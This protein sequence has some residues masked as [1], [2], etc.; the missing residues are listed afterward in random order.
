MNK[1]DYALLFEN[2][3]EKHHIPVEVVEQLN[4]YGNVTIAT[5]VLATLTAKKIRL[6]IVDKYGNVQGYYMP[7][8]YQGSAFAVLG[9]CKIYLDEM[10]RLEL[11]RQMELAGIHNMRANLRYY[12][13]KEENPE[14]KMVIEGLTGILEEI[15]HASTVDKLLL[16]EARA[17]QQYYLAF[18]VMINNSEFAFTKRTRRPP[19]DAM[20]A[21]ISFGNTL[22]YNQF[23]Q[24]IERTN[25]DP[26]ISVVHAA[27][28]RNHS[29]NLD[30][31]DIF[32]PIIV[33]RVIFT[34]IN[35]RQIKAEDF[36]KEN[37]GVYL[38]KNGKKIF[39]KEFEEKLQE[40]LTVKGKRYTYRQLLE[41]EVAKFLKHVTKG[42]KYRP[43]K[44]Y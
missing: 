34:L 1:K 24:V 44:Y 17:R 36:V 42:E 21:L 20:N 32:K 6:A 11:A 23:L 41:D 31:A 14:L 38:S 4:L 16:I 26:R 30:F 33:D 7:W 2:E 18:N 9:Q 43:Y 8:G 15:K 3:Q 39:I 12:Y 27:N 13:K 25:L 10:K 37:G 5:N 22:L 19:E 35:L 29:L 40:S 28:R